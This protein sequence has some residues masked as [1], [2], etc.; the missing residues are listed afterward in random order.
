MLGVAVW[1][2]KGEEGNS[3]RNGKAN[4]WFIR[5]GLTKT[6]TVYGDGLSWG[7]ALCLKFLLGN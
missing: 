1:G 3:H 2:F 5:M 7:Q 6:L 4:V